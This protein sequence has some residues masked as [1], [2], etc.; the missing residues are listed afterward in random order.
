MPSRN[1]VL[2]LAVV[3]G[4]AFF[5]YAIIHILLLRYERGDLY[6]PYST[7]RTD[8]LGTRV[9]YEA[10]DATGR[11]Q[12]SRGVVSLREELAR[13]PDTLFFLGMKSYELNL[14]SQSEISQLSDYVKNGGSVVITLAPTNG[15]EFIP[16]GTDK[17]KDEKKEEKKKDQKAAAVPSA[18]TPPKTA[19]ETPVVA[20]TK[21]EQ[22]EREEFKKAQEI[23]DKNPGMFPEKFKPSLGALWGF[24]LGEELSGKK[25]EDGQSK[26][27]IGMGPG[28][29]TEYSPGGDVLALRVT[30]DPVTEAKVPWKSSLHFVRLEPEWMVRYK[31]KGQPVFIERRWG[32]GEILMASDSYF[33]SDEALL[34]DRK[35]L[36]LNL[37]AGPRGNLLFD[38]VHLGTEEKEG[39][40]VLAHRFRLDG[41]LYGMLIVAALFLWRNSVPLVPPRATQGNVVAGGTVSGKDSRSGLVNLLRRNI[42][43]RDILKTCFTEWKRGVRTGRPQHDSKAAAMETILASPEAGQPEHIVEIYHQ[44]RTINSGSRTQENHATRP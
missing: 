17:K 12:V 33:L 4:L 38:E 43:R 15:R 35:P 22:H 11:Y 42:S 41:Y 20:K 31:A 34:K 24:G 21:Q 6:P 28:E 40:M 39:V 16:S 29:G 23:E 13:K 30:P 19:P 7:L 14:F 5:F 36:L 25:T 10:L 9:F 8:P 26:T 3:A 32:N 44:L 37:V 2:P 27:P 1:V 18:K